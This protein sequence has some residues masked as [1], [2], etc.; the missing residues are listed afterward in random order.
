MPRPDGKSPRKS[1]QLRGVAADKSLRGPGRGPKPGAPNAGRPP[2]AFKALM[3]SMGSRTELLETVARVLDDPTHPAW[4]KMVA[5]VWDR[6]YG[7][8]AQSVDVTSDGKGLQS[9]T[10]GIATA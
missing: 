7:K 2:D 10:L 1:P 9:F 3:A 6:G 8:P 5:L 4:P